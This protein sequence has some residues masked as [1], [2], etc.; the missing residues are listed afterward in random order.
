MFQ[1]REQ[2]ETSENQ[3]NETEIHNLPDKEFK[4]KLIRM[5]TDLRKRMDEH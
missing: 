3:L 2:D 5:L 4:Q 1:E